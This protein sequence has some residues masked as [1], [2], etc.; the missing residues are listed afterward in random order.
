MLRNIGRFA[1]GGH[2]PLFVVAE[3]G[4]NHGGAL[5]R[6]LALVDGAAAAGASAVKLQTLV[7]DRLVAESCPPPAHVSATSLREFFARFELSLDA[8]RAVAARA[9]QHGLAV[10]TTPFAEEVIPGLRDIGFD[11]YKIASGD[12]TYHALVGAAAATGQ[13]VV[14]STGM[15]SVAEVRAALDA[16]RR[17]GGQAL[18]VLHCV[19]SYPTPLDSQ[20][21]RAIHTLQQACALPV[22]LSDH[23]DDGASTAMAAVALGA[24][25]YERHLVLDDD[26]GAID[27]AVS[28]T[29]AQLR[30]LI[31]GAERV[32]RALGSGRKECQPAEA[33][34]LAA[35]RRGLYA[36]R[37]LRA[38]DVVTRGDVAVLRPQTTVAP[39]HLESLVGSVMSRDMLPGEPFVMEDIAAADQPSRSIA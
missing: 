24:C 12:V 38:G 6:A 16:A 3:I 15:S 14:L 26:A 29:P 30:A 18:A 28:S 20:N 37:L 36:S 21:L 1:I 31:Q 22:G 5:D 4:L 9:R 13:P 17:A 33:V 10:M 34:N 11:A 8:H 23:S 39:F 7:A 32:R 35:S 27:R 25:I 2:A 19:S